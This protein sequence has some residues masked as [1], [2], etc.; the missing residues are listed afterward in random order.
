[1]GTESGTRDD[2]S[3][4]RGVFEF[5]LQGGFEYYDRG[6]GGIGL[7]DR[8]AGGTNQ[9]RFGLQRPGGVGLPCG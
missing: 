3:R 4:D 7:P 8:N 2:L 1:M 6:V 5:Y 9:S